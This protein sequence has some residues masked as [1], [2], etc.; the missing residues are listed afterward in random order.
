MT[1]CAQPIDFETLIAYWL[2]ELDAA[3]EA[4]LEEHFFACAHCT[5]RLE[6]LAALASGIRAAVRD[7][8]VA[9][10]LTP[11]F[12]GYLKEQGLRHLVARLV[13]EEAERH[14]RALALGERL[15]APCEPLR[16]E[17]ERL[18]RLEG[19]RAAVGLQQPLAAPGPAPD[20]EHR[21]A[22]GAEDEGGDLLRVADL[23]RAQALE[24]HEEHLLREVVR[25]VGVAQVPEAVQPHARREPPIELGFGR[26]VAALARGR[27]ASRE[28]G[29]LESVFPHSASIAATIC[30]DV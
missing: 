9:M 4:P 15:E 11:R 6:G 3:A 24:R 17:R 19:L 20:L 7:G 22:A 8:A 1:R 27:D 23:P 14:H 21:H 18:G 5:R 28:L 10:A 30:R 12:L 25:G 29:I 2:G 16:V 26:G 13:R